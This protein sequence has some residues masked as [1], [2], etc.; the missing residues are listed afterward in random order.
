MPAIT[1][2]KTCGFEGAHGFTGCVAGITKFYHTIDKTKRD[3]MENSCAFYEY[4]GKPYKTLAEAW[5]VARESY[6]NDYWRQAY[7]ALILENK[8]RKHNRLIDKWREEALK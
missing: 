8:P 2:C 1:T 5:K 3:C 4:E 6:P 7:D